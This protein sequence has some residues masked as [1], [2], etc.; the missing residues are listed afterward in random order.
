MPL[1]LPS[2]FQRWL[3][4]S[5][6]HPFAYMEIESAGQSAELTSEADWHGST[7]LTNVD[8]D[9]PPPPAGGDVILAAAAGTNVNTTATNRVPTSDIDTSSWSGT[10]PAAQPYYSVI[11]ENDT[12]DD[13]N[14]IYVQRTTVGSTTA[15][16]RGACSMASIISQVPDN[17]HI[18][19]VRILARGQY[20]P[21]FLG[22]S[23]TLEGIISDG[24]THDHATA[25]DIPTSGAWTDLTF[26]WTTN[27]FDSDN[28]WTKE[29]LPDITNMGVQLYFATG[30]NDT[31][32][33]RCSQL[34]LWVEWYDFETT[35]SLVTS[36]FD[37]GASAVTANKAVVSLNDLIPTNAGL[38]YTIEGSNTDWSGAVSLGS[39][40]DGSKVT[41]YRYYRVTAS[42]T[43][44]GTATAVLKSILI[45]IPDKVYKFSTLADDTLDAL[46]LMGSIPGR[47]VKIDLK[48]FVT[49]G[50][51]MSVELT[52]TDTVDE[53]VRSQYFRGRH[54][55]VWLGLQTGSV[56]TGD[57]LTNFQGTV[58]DYSITESTVTVMA[59][60][61]SKDL[62]IKV[63]V[64][65]NSGVPGT[66]I[67]EAYSGHMVAT[68]ADLLD[69]SGI[70]SRY[71]DRGSFDTVEASVGPTYVVSRTLTEEQP[72]KKYIGEL[73]ELLG[74]YLHTDERGKLVMT[75]YLSTA[76]SQETWDSN[77]IHT[78]WSYD[79]GMMALKNQVYL[80]YD[81][82]FVDGDIEDYSNIDVSLDGSSP[83]NWGTTFTKTI[84]S[85]WL[86]DDTV[87]AAITLRE[88]TRLKDGLGVFKCRTSLDQANIQVGD[89]ISID[90]SKI[91]GIIKQDVGKGDTQKFLV[92]QKT[93]N[94]SGGTMS[95][96]MVE[97]R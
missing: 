45:T 46:P 81:H 73:L 38:T 85:K 82:A 20:T 61:A 39:V 37:L 19:R 40:A 64:A 53:M 55:A 96:E 59:R 31:Q 77:I 52:R 79:A 18:R 32:N 58:S 86:A 84:K 3:E 33:C 26:D 9:T 63:P 95:W 69:K 70:A 78:G 62:D 72:A 57:L 4:Q 43:S 75:Q 91:T 8:H 50:A 21:L 68:I 74:A 94:I 60:D 49:V 16:F 11:D 89:M 24:T 65:A 56:T 29:T 66:I 23:R 12:A 10:F 17:A 80:Y 13:A 93:W 7:T 5:S 48:S 34:K 51:A 97:A 25:Q 27:P 90:T 6:R 14:Y 41:G 88:A 67:S 71:I 47:A 76:A 1:T 92:T 30:T 22:S 54:V 83:A 2:N 36:T 42:F 28:P 35:G 87:A 44:D 15:S